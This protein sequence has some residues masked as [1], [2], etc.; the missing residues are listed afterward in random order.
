MCVQAG[1][2]TGKTTT[3]RML[4]ASTSKRGLYIAFNRAIADEAKGRFT[5]N[6]QC[7]TAHS[8][9]FQ[10]Y[11]R[12]FSARLNAPRIPS[13]EVA[14]GLDIRGDMRIGDRKVSPL[15]RAYWCRGSIP[16]WV[17]S[18]GVWSFWC[19]AAVYWLQSRAARLAP[20]DGGVW[21]DSE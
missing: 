14:A 20:S 4:A 21:G 9:A 10:T 1:A 5:P 17:Y 18:V 12:R 11:G 15:A 13:R 6:V 2:G 3:L 8:I 7:R 19:R 16:T